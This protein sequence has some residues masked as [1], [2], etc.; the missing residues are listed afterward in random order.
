MTPF[1]KAEPD[2]NREKLIVERFGFESVTF[3]APRLPASNEH[4]RALAGGRETTTSVV[5]DDKNVRAARRFYQKCERHPQTPKK[6]QE[7]IDKIDFHF[8]SLKFC[9]SFLKR[10]PRIHHEED[11]E[12]S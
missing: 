1:S 5:S 4:G 10:K 12:D 9:T 6:V 8:H 11:L 7:F 3:L 2:A